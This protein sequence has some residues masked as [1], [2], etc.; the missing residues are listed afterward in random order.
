M[1]TLILLL[2]VTLAGVQPQN[3]CPKAA[4]CMWGGVD[5]C[6]APGGITAITTYDCCRACDEI[7]DPI[8]NGDECGCC[9]PTT[10]PA[11]NECPKAACCG[12]FN[13]WC[14][15]G[16]TGV[17]SADCCRAC[18]ERP[19]E[20]NCGC[21]DVTDDTVVICPKGSYNKLYDQSLCADCAPGSY[22]NLENQSSCLDILLKC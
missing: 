20:D 10:P 5:H 6:M 17:T 16:L 18:E 14:P 2:F 7:T 13:N 8:P 3:D 22:Q 15:N 12:N 4:C 1:W 9:Y 11:Q 19:D 21:C